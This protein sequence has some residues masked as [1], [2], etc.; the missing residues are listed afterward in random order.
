MLCISDH[1][2]GTKGSRSEDVRRLDNIFQMYF[3]YFFLGISD[4][5]G[6]KGSRAEDIR[7]LDGTCRPESGAL[8]TAVE[9]SPEIAGPIFFSSSYSILKKSSLQYQ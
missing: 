5:Y 2:G 7:R 3:R 9:A 8:P 6:R 4:H 1:Y